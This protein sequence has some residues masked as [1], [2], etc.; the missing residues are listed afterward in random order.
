MVSL[1]SS[2]LTPS[3]APFHYPISYLFLLSS[4]FPIPLI[5]PCCILCYRRTRMKIRF[6]VFTTVWYWCSFN[7]S[8]SNTI[9]KPSASHLCH[10][11]PEY[12]D[13]MFLWNTGIDLWNYMSPKLKKTLTLRMKIITV[14]KQQLYCVLHYSM[15]FNKLIF[16][17]VI[18]PFVPVRC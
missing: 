8:S 12:G 16:E 2:S 15:D 1:I 4:I 14:K 7:P 17:W 5:Y 10:F 18:V 3:S 13:S 6:Y 11:S 9:Y